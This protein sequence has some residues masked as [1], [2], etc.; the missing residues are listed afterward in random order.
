MH[1][2]RECQGRAS[3]PERGESRIVA[4]M[5]GPTP[6]PTPISG[7]HALPGNAYRANLYVY[8]PFGRIDWY[9]IAP[10]AF[11]QG[12]YFTIGRA[13]DC[14]IILTDGSV[15]AHHAY[16]TM[17]QGA[18]WLRDLGSTNG[19]LVNEVRT[20]GE[21]LE[22]GD[23]LRMGATDLRF[24]LSHKTGPAQLLLEFIGGPNHGKSLATFGSST[25]IGR[26]NC[27]VNLPGTGVAPQH[28]RI[29]AYGPE[30]IYV[31][32]LRRDNETW[33]NGDRVLGIQT[34]KDGDVLRI[35][36]HQIRLRVTDEANA[37]DAV[38]AG[39]GTLQLEGSGP[40]AGAAAPVAQIMV[41][42]DDLKRL[43]AARL[44]A[45]S[46][47]ERTVLEMAPLGESF[48]S[49]TAEP[50]IVASSRRSTSSPQ[51]LQ[52]ASHPR[53]AGGRAPD[54]IEVLPTPAPTL[55]GRRRFFGLWVLLL[56]LVVVGAALVSLRLTSI[57]RTVAVAGQ[58]FPGDQT[59]VRS[60]VSGLVETVYVRLGD[61]V[62]AG[63]PLLRVADAAVRAEIDALTARIDPIQRTVP[64]PV[65]VASAAGGD[66]AAALARAE[67]DA[68]V[69]R[70]ELA[71]RTASFNRREV[72]SS[73]IDEART[74]L[75]T[76]E[77]RLQAL[78]G[79]AAPAAAPRA[80]PGAP[81]LSDVARLTEL[82]SLRNAA[83]A[84]LYRAVVAPR[85]GVVMNA[86]G[87]RI[88]VGARLDAEQPALVVADVLEVR[89]ELTV[90]KA[91]Q[92]MV[93]VTP[94]A[95]LTPDGFEEPR[96]PVQ[97]TTLEP[98]T[99]GNVKLEGRVDNPSGVLRPGQAVRLELEA[100]PVDGLTW[101]LDR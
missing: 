41:S 62:S 95:V 8:D 15:S 21:P 30:L 18:I 100:T 16:L 2:G 14:N 98:S 81:P 34:A 68:A 11:T 73:A 50:S 4:S 31:V 87:Q 99:T 88:Q 57:R 96:L 39:D 44:D 5:S 23:V 59:A 61:R 91:Q 13:P 32:S 22:H 53:V 58:V 9:A 51:Q 92:A 72:P 33:L 46:N 55:L 90:S 77:A 52:R 45:L 80:V 78:R 94:R 86:E 42:S 65:R 60:P 70:A 101:L 29:D 12:R 36:E 6:V 43:D 47:E 25:T 1:V 71:E 97:L 74:R 54:A 69:A 10:Q 38:A 75:E 82:L 85:S 17:E 67:A 37:S 76:M 64:E 79:V 20:S 84:R 24:L 56:L 93:G 7:L 49:P 89:V 63:D 27:A 3:W 28:V 83:E 66:A 40:M 19:V 35:G 26:L 48:V